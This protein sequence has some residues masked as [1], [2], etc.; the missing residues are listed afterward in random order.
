MAIKL[1]EKRPTTE[2]E[3]LILRPFEMSDAAR[4]QA[5]AGDADVASTTLRI[6]HPYE[7]GLAEL[8]I[9]SHPDKIAEGEIIFALVLKTDATLIGAMG[10]V[11]NRDHENAELGYWIGK[12]YWNHG[13][14]TEAARAAVA[15]AFSVVR[16][17]RV[18]AHHF[19]RN[20]ASGRVMKKIGM[21]HEGRQ[22]Q[23]VKKWGKFEDVELYGIIRDDVRRSTA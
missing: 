18:F 3:R 20:V 11:V 5:L 1:P 13:Y 2:T 14:A 17:R 23:H 4:V 19:S 22:R 8:W 21:K 9:E 16:L 12:P 6:P 7:D 10:L 15:Y